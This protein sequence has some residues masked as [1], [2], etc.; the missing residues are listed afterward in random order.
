MNDTI[1]RYVCYLS[2]ELA[3]LEKRLSKDVSDEVSLRHLDLVSAH[4]VAMRKGERA[5]TWRLGR[6]AP[7]SLDAVYAGLG[8]ARADLNY[9]IGTVFR[10]Q[11]T[12]G[13]DSLR[14]L[15][16]LLE[17]AV[18]EVSWVAERWEVES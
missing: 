17:N 8:A 1:N 15:S 2:S 11:V 3:R 10:L 4:L 5:A 13:R 12:G 7:R 16:E 18:D 9:L 6:P 14:E